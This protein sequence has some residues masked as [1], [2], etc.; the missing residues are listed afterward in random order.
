MIVLCLFLGASSCKKSQVQTTTRIEGEVKKKAQDTMKIDSKD[1]TLQIVTGSG[2]V[3]GIDLTN[4]APVRGVQ[5]TI[6][7]V[8]MTEVYITSRAAGFLADFNK[9]SG[10][11]II[12]STPGDKIA[13]GTGLIEEVTCDKVGSA[14]LSGIKIA[15]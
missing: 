9:E 1:A 7:G 11:V 5:F 10:K 12:V 3:L 2:N 4:N 15:K 6:G 14:I 8:K 13:P